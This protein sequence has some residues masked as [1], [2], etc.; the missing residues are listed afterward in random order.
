M[1]AAILHRRLALAAQAHAYER[2]DFDW[3][4]DLRDPLSRSQETY[5]DVKCPCGID[6]WSVMLR[7]KIEPSCRRSNISGCGREVER[8]IESVSKMAPPTEYDS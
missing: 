7:L 8:E 1:D 4:D 6:L 5:Y 2:L 3:I